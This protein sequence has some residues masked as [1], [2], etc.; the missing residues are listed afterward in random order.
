ML[1]LFYLLRILTPAQREACITAIHKEGFEAIDDALANVKSE[2]ATASV[3]ADL[4][5][6]QAVIM[7]YQ[8]GYHALD[9]AVKVRLRAWLAHVTGWF[10]SL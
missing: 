4:K 10:Q 7:R 1:F 8:G 5:S 3:D 2:E 6:I 9:E